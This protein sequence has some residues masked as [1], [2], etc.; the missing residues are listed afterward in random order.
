[1]QRN[2]L[3]LTQSR[4]SSGYND[5]VGRFY[6]FP[7]KCI[8]QF[9]NTP[10][11]FVYYEPAKSGEGV[12]FGYGKILVQPTKDKKDADH[13]FVEITDYK[14]FVEPVSFKDDKGKI[15][16]SAS[17]HYN[18]QNAVRKIPPL[19][20]DEICLDGKIR[21]NFRADAHLIKVLG[22]QLIA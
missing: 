19:L 22:E 8:G 16:E 10:V 1:M 6:H 15:R 7:D 21:L 20:L 13:Y 9:K 18:A 3:V 14:P 2:C 12:Y 17:P 4:E 11:E 5:F